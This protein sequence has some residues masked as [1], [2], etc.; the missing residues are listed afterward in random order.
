MNFL[1]QLV[2]EWY[3]HR[4]YFVS[5]NIKIGKRERG[6]WSGEMDVVAFEP[7]KKTLVHLETSCDA[8]GWKKRKEVFAKKFKTAKKYYKKEF[9]F[10]IR[11]IKRIAI[12]YNKCK[13]NKIADNTGN[14]ETLSI[15]KLGDEIIKEM[16]KRGGIMRGIVPEKYPLLRAIQFAI[17]RIDK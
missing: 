12:A 6:G 10:P 14:I 5:T 8:L 13:S 17:W 16:R 2:A 7:K 11:E 3:E 4:G 9:G 1:E 15:Q